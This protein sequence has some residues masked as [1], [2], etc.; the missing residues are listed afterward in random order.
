MPAR[1]T[2]AAP[3][4]ASGLM[5]GRGEARVDERGELVGGNLLE[6]HHRPGLVERPLRAEHPLHQARLGAGEDVADLALMLDRGAQRVLDRAAVEAADRL[7][8]VE[9]DDDLAAARRGEPR[10]AARTLPARAA[11]RRGRSA[12]RETT[13]VSAPSGDGVGRV[14]DFGARR[15]ASTSRSQVRARSQLRLGRDE[16][17]RVALEERDVRAEAADGDLDGQRAAPRHRGERVADQRR[18]AVAARRDQEDL[19]AGGEVAD[20]PVELDHAV[21]RTPPPARPR[22]RRTDCPLRRST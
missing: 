11:R 17:A 2:I 4:P 21:R 9:R 15:A 20:Q 10:R 14:A 18:L 12:R 8:L 3:S 5:P 13:R 1:S 7:E 22:R 16:R 6:P 19:L